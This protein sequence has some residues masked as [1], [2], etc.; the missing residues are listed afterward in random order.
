MKIDLKTALYLAGGAVV[1]AVVYQIVRKGQD[2]ADAVPAALKAV[3][4]AINPVS[5]QNIAYKGANAIAQAVS[6]DPS[7]T[8]GTWLYDLVHGGS[9]NALVAPTP[10]AAALKPPTGEGVTDDEFM[11]NAKPG[12]VGGFVTGTG[13]AAFSVYPNPFRGKK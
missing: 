12:N 13:G 2:V 10:L 9:D 6:G 3:G 1:V 8:F 4:E 5:D 11:A 7:V